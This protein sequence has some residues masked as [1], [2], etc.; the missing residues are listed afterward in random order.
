M[1]LCFETISASYL[2]ACDTFAKIYSLVLVLN[3]N[4][5]MIIV[6]NIMQF[7]TV[8][9]QFVTAYYKFYCLTILYVP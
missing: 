9:G 2:K 8:I 5:K 7:L 1:I 6:E 4:E 3:I